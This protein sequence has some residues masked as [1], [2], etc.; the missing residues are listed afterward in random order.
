LEYARDEVGDGLSVF[1]EA[2]ALNARALWFYK[3]RQ[4]DEASADCERAIDVLRANL[5][6]LTLPAVETLLTIWLLYENL[7]RISLAA[8]WRKSAVRYQFL[9][10]EWAAQMEPEDRPCW[11]ALA[12]Q[13]VGDDLAEEVLRSERRLREAKEML[14]PYHEALWQHTLGQLYYRQGAADKA[15]LAFERSLEIWRRIGVEYSD[16]TSQLLNS[17]LAA[18]RAGRGAQA[19]A[20]LMELSTRHGMDSADV[21]AEILAARGLAAV[22]DGAVASGCAMLSEAEARA[23]DIGDAALLARVLIYIARAADVAEPAGRCEWERV[24][25]AIQA[26]GGP[27]VV[28]ASLTAV[29][30]IALLTA[31]SPLESVQSAVKL[32]AAALDEDDLEVWWALP[33]LEETMA[34]HR[35]PR[36]GPDSAAWLRVLVAAKARIPFRESSIPAMMMDVKTPNLFT[37][38]ACPRVSSRA[39]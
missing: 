9:A 1:Y 21:A 23:A 12:A 30:E 24:Q 5:S 18:L 26:A 33:G 28:G 31:D 36:E 3:A 38:G 37:F 19:E 13:T 4:F 10:A 25:Q 14:S 39:I 15:L 2:W 27:D 6:R 34:R 16:V 32:T 35:S 8:G 7:T 29:A 17:A 22:L 11:S 20:Y